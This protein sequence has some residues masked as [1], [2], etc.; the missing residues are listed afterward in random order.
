MVRRPAIYEL[1]GERGL[2]EILD[3]AGGVLASG[4]LK[5]I[6]VER[7]EANQRRTMLTVELPQGGAG[8]GAAGFTVQDGDSI[9]VSQILPASQQSV[10]LEGHVI[11][12]GK[13]PY[14]EGMTVAD[15]L[16]SY[17]DLMPEPSDHA[18]LV[19]LRAPDYRP[20]TVIFDLEDALIGNS[21]I[22]LEPFDLVRIFSRY[23]VDAPRV[24]IQGEVLRPGEYPMPQG[25][26]AAGLVRM[27]GGLKR[28]AYREEA[29]LSTYEV[30][31][32]RKVQ[33]SHLSIAVGKALDGDLGA[34]V[35]LKPG[36]VLGIRQ[37]T[38]WQDIGASVSIRGEV[39]HPGTYGIVQGER[40]SSLLKRTGGF[41]ET[42]SPAAADLE[43]IEV[44]Q[45]NERARQEMIRRIESTPVIL[46]PGLGSSQNGAEMEQA[47]QQQRNEVLEALKKHEVTGR[48]VISI[49]ADVSKW[50]NTADD[51]ELRSGDQVVIPKRE[52][53]VLVSGQ[54]YNATAISYVPGKDAAWYLRQAGGIT[55]AGDAGATFVLRANGSVVARRGNW[56]NGGMLGVRMRPGDSIIV[57][58]KPAGGSAAWRNLI[59]IAQVMS[60]VAITGAVAGIF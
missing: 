42:A 41:R 18:E 32:G 29:D 44:R 16:G 10:Y 21:A 45:F 1:G 48:M 27:A 19:R 28:S 56:L 30:E 43:R 5:E 39:E 2:K 31:G 46:R 20:E 26:T 55:H 22:K 37:I 49:S 38:A 6:R 34:D 33:L 40:L 14:R 25:M 11:R 9:L 23:E 54:V 36:D 47:A 4:S 17:R 53:F 13:Y 12:P 58:E 8:A 52:N 3:L 59:S 51:V 7:I 24:T 50:E 60:S 57:P 15:L 35:V